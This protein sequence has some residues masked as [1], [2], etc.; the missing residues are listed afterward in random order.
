MSIWRFSKKWVY[1]NIS[2]CYNGIALERCA[3]HQF[4]CENWWQTII[5]ISQDTVAS[6]LEGRRLHDWKRN[7]AEEYWRICT[8][9]NL[10]VIM[11][12][13]FRSIYSYQKK[14]ECD[15][16]DPYIMR[17]KSDRT[18]P[19]K[20]VRNCNHK[21]ECKVFIGLCPGKPRIPYSGGFWACYTGRQISS[22]VSIIVKKKEGS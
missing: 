5:K 11:K 6:Y 12:K 19:D 16:S 3:G 14:I 4:S 9:T 22:A 2:F 15:E 7:V 18:W 21:A 8:I 10:Y 20:G 13:R 1:T 17:H